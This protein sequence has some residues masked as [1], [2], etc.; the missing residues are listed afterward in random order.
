MKKILLVSGVLISLLSGITNASFLGGV[1]SSAT[2]NSLMTS[3]GSGLNLAKTRRLAVDKALWNMHANDSYSSHWEIYA[4][5]LEEQ[6][7]EGVS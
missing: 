6:C 4:S 3:S 1:L 7:K 2:A 5:Y